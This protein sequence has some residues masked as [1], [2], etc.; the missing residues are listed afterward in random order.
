MSSLQPDFPRKGP[1]ATV[2]GFLSKKQHSSHLLRGQRIS[3]DQKR[4]YATQEHELCWG[5]K[6]CVG[7]VLGTR[8]R[9]QG[10]K[11]EH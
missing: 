7:G 8:L 11:A 6:V 4:Q 9:Q 5:W 3:L 1:K 10:E 2:L